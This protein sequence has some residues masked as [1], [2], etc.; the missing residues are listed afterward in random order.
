ML[1]LNPD[2]VNAYNNRGV[3]YVGKGDFDLAIKDYTTAIELNP[4]LAPV[5]YNRGEV[6]L[7]L[8]KWKEAK[9]DLTAA[10]DM[11]V[12]IIAAFHNFY[13]D[14][15]TFERRRGFKLPEDIALIL[16]QRRR[17]RYPKTQKILDADGNPIESP[18]VVNLRSQLRNAGIPLSEYVKTKSAFGINIASTEVFVVDKATRDELIAL[19]PASADIL[20][21]FLHGKDLR[22]WHVDTPQ[23]WLIF[24][25]RGIAIN[26]Y[27]A[28]LKYLEKH[29]NP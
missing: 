1:K 2:Y 13:G 24:S 14:V 18:N 20:K 23:Q 21:P 27:P 4:Q 16:T 12:D 26:D 6:W 8:K 19:H 22:R 9:V 7:R 3:I 29:R 17:T 5:Y 11:G 28:I 10:K 25:C 15:E